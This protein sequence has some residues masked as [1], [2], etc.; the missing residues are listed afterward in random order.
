[1][2]FLSKYPL[3][4]LSFSDEGL[5]VDFDNAVYLVYAHI[6]VILHC[7]CLMHQHTKLNT[8]SCMCQLDQRSH[9]HSF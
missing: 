7:W 1:M 5:L 9:S 4:C 6:V 8:V 2:V 3:K